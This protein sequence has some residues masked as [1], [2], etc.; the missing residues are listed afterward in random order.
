VSV[1]LS[2]IRCNNNPLHLQERKTELY[3]AENIWERIRKQSRNYLRYY[4]D[5]RP[6]ELR[7]TARNHWQDSR[8]PAQDLNPRTPKHKAGEKTVCLFSTSR[9]SDWL[10]FLHPAYISE[11]HSRPN[12]LSLKLD[13]MPLILKMTATY[14]SETSLSTYVTTQCQNQD[15]YNVQIPGVKTCKRIY[16]KGS[17]VHRKRYSCPY[18]RKQYAWWGDVGVQ[19]QSFLPSESDQPVPNRSTPRIRAASADRIGSWVGPTASLY[20]L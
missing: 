14:F 3:L 15:L 9:G 1:P 20:D 16:F 8:C 11:Q 6:K 18:D 12:H 4:P 5:I 2:V 13:V 10:H 7:K 17:F 19:L